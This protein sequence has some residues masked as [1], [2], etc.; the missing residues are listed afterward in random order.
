MD[1]AREKL[2][3]NIRYGK[4][5]GLAGAVFALIAHQQITSSWIYTRCPPNPPAL[6]FT[7]A[8]ISAGVA[9]VTGMWSWSVRRALRRDPDAHL[10][11]KTDRFIA[12]LSVALTVVI[13][14]FIVF[15]SV[16]VLFLRCER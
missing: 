13:L 7:I 10:T 16:A 9:I 11:M 14:L 4:W 8:A 3:A 6:V 1:A 5:A 15:S 2:A 12:S